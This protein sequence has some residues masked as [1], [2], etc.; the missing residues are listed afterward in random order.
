MK[1]THQ[2]KILIFKPAS[3]NRLSSCILIAFG[4]VR[5][6]GRKYYNIPI[7][8]PQKGDRAMQSKTFTKLF[9]QLEKLT[10]TQSKKAEEYLHNKCAIE[11]IEDTIGTAESC[12]YC[13]SDSFHKWGIHPS[14]SFRWR[15]RMLQVPLRTKADHR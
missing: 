14:T 2:E 5:T 7:V 13:H 9:K 15:Y 12:P 11:S 8:T 4:S 10:F 6:K 3:L 1:P